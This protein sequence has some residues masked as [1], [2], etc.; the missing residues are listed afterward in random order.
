M[1]KVYLDNSCIADIDRHNMWSHLPNVVY[2]WGPVNWLE[3]TNCNSSTIKRRL[4]CLSHYTNKWIGES[5]DEKEWPDLTDQFRDICNQPLDILQAAKNIEIANCT[6][7]D[8]YIQDLWIDDLEDFPD[9]SKSST[10]QFLE[11]FKQWVSRHQTQ[12][13]DTETLDHV[14]CLYMLIRNKQR[15]KPGPSFKHDFLDGQ[16]YA[17]S[18][19]CDKLVAKDGVLINTANYCNKVLSSFNLKTVEVV[20]QE[21]FLK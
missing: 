20:K 1:E 7:K 15:K 9:I 13:L 21:A 6:A 19:R 3:A 5:V 11:G 18:L 10:D 12:T 4:N 14:L 16:N 2:C 8:G 17:I